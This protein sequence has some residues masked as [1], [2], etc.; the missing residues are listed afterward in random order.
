MLGF[1]IQIY[2]NLYGCPVYV[3]VSLIFLSV[4]YQLLIFSGAN[5]SRFD[6]KANYD[7][8]SMCENQ[9]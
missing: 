1:A 5:L 9:N 3:L 2:F 4:L 8:I 7:Y 6:S